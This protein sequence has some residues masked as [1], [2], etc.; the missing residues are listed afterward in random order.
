MMTNLI[1]FYT[2]VGLGWGTLAA[3]VQRRLYGKNVI[4]C[5][6]VNTV[7]WPLAMVFCYARQKKDLDLD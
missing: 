1:I 5:G 3:F 4:L 2:I 6:C 7:I